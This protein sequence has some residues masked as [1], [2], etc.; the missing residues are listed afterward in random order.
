MKSNIELWNEIETLGREMRKFSK[1]GN[2]E[3]EQEAR[4]EQKKKLAEFMKRCNK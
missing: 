2:Y 3:K 4:K 1:D